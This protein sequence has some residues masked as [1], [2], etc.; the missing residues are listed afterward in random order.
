MSLLDHQA[1]LTSTGHQVYSTM[2]A[3][4]LPVFT[5]SPRWHFSPFLR[6]IYSTAGPNV[7]WTLR[8]SIPHQR[9]RNNNKVPVFHGITP[10]R[11]WTTTSPVPLTKVPHTTIIVYTIFCFRF[12]LV[13]LE[14]FFRLLLHKGLCSLS[15]GED[16][17][18]I[19]M[20]DSESDL[21]HLSLNFI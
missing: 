3:S 20:F 9:R 6:P 16:S 21:H 10:E 2:E 17:R 13:S 8:L 18:S 4:Q 12:V 14:L 19:N 5:R 7:L 1:E 11:R 15:L